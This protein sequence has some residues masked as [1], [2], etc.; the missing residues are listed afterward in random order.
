MKTKAM[1]LITWILVSIILFG[2]I[3]LLTPK[4]IGQEWTAEQKEVWEVVKADIEKFKQG[5]V[6]GI[7]ASRHEDVIIWW[8]SEPMPFDKKMAMYR[9]SRWIKYDKPDMW[10]IEP[11]LFAS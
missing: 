6:E 4:A 11:P 3:L 9:Y 10:E 1:N 7:S 5:D 8:G 2:I